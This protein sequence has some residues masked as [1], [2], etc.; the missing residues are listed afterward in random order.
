MPN[1]SRV[2]N[3]DLGTLETEKVCDARDVHRVSTEL[4]VS[5]GLPSLFASCR[6]SAHPTRSSLWSQGQGQVT[7]FWDQ[8]SRSNWGEEM[9]NYLVSLIRRVRGKIFWWLAF[10]PWDSNCCLFPV[11]R[12][13]R[14]PCSLVERR[15]GLGFP[16][17]QPYTPAHTQ[18][19]SINPWST[20]HCVL[21]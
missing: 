9:L 17:E 7:L 2:E 1:F 8:I 13:P 16:Q 21:P 10:L 19:W 6:L 5:L 15:G 18:A 14:G 4:I 12:V 11:G 3:S 20:F